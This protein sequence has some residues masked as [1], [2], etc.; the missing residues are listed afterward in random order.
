LCFTFSFH[1]S[2]SPYKMCGHDHNFSTY[3]FT[4]GFQRPLKYRN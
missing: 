2:Y 3:L 1:S 4:I